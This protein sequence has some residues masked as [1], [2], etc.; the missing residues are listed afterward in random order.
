[1]QEI[2][3]PY[4]KAEIDPMNIMGTS[5]WDDQQFD[6]YND[7]ECPNCNKRFKIRQYDIEIIRNFEIEKDE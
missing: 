7:N 6:W 4:C 5:D 1:M 2:N 3:C